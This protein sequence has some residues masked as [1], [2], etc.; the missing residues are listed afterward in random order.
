MNIDHSWMWRR[1]DDNGFLLDEFV[2]RVDQEFLNFAFDNPRFMNNGQIKCPCSKYGNTKFLNR[3]DAHLHIVKNGFTRGYNIWYAHGESLNTRDDV[4]A[5]L[6]MVTRGRAGGRVRGRGRGRGH[7]FLLRH[8]QDDTQCQNNLKI[9]WENFKE[10][11]LCREVTEI[12]L[13]QRCHRKN[14]GS[15][16]FIDNKSKRISEEYLAKTGCTDVS[17]QS[18]FDLSTWYDVTGGPSRGRLYGFGSNSS[19]TSASSVSSTIK[20]FEEKLNE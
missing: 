19:S 2:A 15:G 4:G 11:E 14:K 13:F 18:S 17:S 20:A 8:G 6:R 12:E 3:S 10:K 7:E 9:C 1:L 5:L 16:E